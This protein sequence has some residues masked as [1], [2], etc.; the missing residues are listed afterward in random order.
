VI[1]GLVDEAVREGARQS[2]ACELL[3]LDARTLQRWKSTGFVDD[4]RAG[5]TGVV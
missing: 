3:G 1:A 4:R 2:Q 5:P